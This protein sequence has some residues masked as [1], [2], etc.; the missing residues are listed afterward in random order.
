MKLSAAAPSSTTTKRL[1]RFFFLSALNC[2]LGVLRIVFD[3]EDVYRLHVVH[4]HALLCGRAGEGGAAVD[5]PWAADPTAVPPNDALD[6][7]EPD[8]GAF[9]LA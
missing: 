9:E 4:G 8:P 7:G 2:Q 1:A 6:E 5:S 3:E